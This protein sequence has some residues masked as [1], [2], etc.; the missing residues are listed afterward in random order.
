M[1]SR[2]D[3]QLRR[4][5]QRRNAP[6][7]SPG[8]AT[9]GTGNAPLTAGHTSAERRDRP[10][11]TAEDTAASAL[12]G[13]AAAGPQGPPSDAPMAPRRQTMENAAGT[14]SDAPAVNRA[15]TAG[16]VDRTPAASSPSAR[17]GWWHQGV[18]G[19]LAL[20]LGLTL[21]LGPL[22]A[23]SLFARPLALL[24][25]AVVFAS[26]LAPAAEWLARWL[27]RALAVVLVYA[28]VAAA[29][30][31]VGWFV[32][33]RLVAQAWEAMT[34]LPAL[35]EE[36]RQL[37]ARWDGG[38]GE[39][40][41]NAAQS[42]VTGVV[43]TL[44]SLPLTLVSV[45]LEAVLVFVLA[46]YW[47]LGAPALRRFFVGLFPPR[48]QD[49]VSR[50][51]GE[52]GGTMG[53]FVR[54]V[55]L[56]SLLVGVVVYVG[57]RVIGVRYPL[58]LALAA[59]LG[60]VVPIVGPFIGAVP[61]VAV[62]LLHSPHQAAVVLAFYVVLQQLESHILVPRLVK[63]QAHIPPLL[64]IFAL[65]AGAAVGGILGALVAI[66]LSGAVR[67]LVVRVLAPALRRCSGAA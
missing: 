37:T 10:D 55:A 43:E 40:V 46:V 57:M 32:L 58:L 3:P 27:P 26:A 41:L 59:A 42:H 8:G 19:A 49:R 51:L 61:A 24:V 6:D 11:D 2:V 29:L 64:G 39:R 53:G 30:A 15:G 34:N 5:K 54:A 1:R 62:A 47:L 23:L 18:V 16:T 20:A 67:V 35:L 52:M 33:P 17:E 50:V 44:I 14:I 7:G 21:A 22:W 65:M 4:S 36:A 56:D 31:A 60:E 45:A 63:N 9:E 13:G 28:L 38:T 12:L 66:P 25:M 48:L